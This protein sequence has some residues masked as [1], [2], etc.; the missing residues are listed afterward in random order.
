M[1]NK[2]NRKRKYFEIKQ[3]KTKK[4]RKIISIKENDSEVSIMKDEIQ[5]RNEGSL[6]EF[7]KSEEKNK[8]NKI[9]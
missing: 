2:L 6:E 1:K 4:K 5:H 7:W 8:K 3:N 9:Y